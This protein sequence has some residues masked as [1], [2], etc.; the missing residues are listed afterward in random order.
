MVLCLFLKEREES[1]AHSPQGQG[2]TGRCERQALPFLSLVSSRCSPVQ[3]SVEGLPSCLWAR[4]EN[5]HAG[6]GAASPLSAFSTTKDH[7][8]GDTQPAEV[9]STPKQP[10]LGCCLTPEQIHRY[11]RMDRGRRSKSVCI[12]AVWAGGARGGLRSG[13]EHPFD[14]VDSS[15]P[16]CDA[17][18]E[19][20]RTGRSKADRPGQGLS[21]VV[22]HL[23]PSLRRGLCLF[24]PSCELPSILNPNL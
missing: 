3:T 7:I 11:G 10:P 21:G 1:C 20:P 2:E 13:W 5:A 18:A 6:P 4:G 22:L 9:H 24:S 12:G 14:P 15:V 19:G 17:A 16:G 8:C 23:T